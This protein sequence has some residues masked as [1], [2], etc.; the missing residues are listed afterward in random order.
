[1]KKRIIS[2]IMIACL[3]ISFAGCGEKGSDSKSTKTVKVKSLEPSEKVEKIESVKNEEDFNTVYANFAFEAMKASKEA[4]EN[5]MISPLSIIT[6]LSMTASGADNDTLK[7]MEKVLYGGESIDKIIP[8]LMYYIDSI[9]GFGTDEESLK[10][11]NSIWIKDDAGLHVS[12]DFLKRNAET[13]GNEVFKVAFDDNTLAALNNWVKNNTDGMIE[14]I[15]DKMDEDAVMYLINAI[16]FEARWRETYM[17]YQVHDNVTFHDENGTNES[18]TMLCS[19]ESGYMED[20]TCTGV[21]KAYENG[22]SFVALLPN[23]GM[24]V[25]DLVKSMDGGKWNNLMSNIDYNPD[26][27][28]KIPQFKF[29][30]ATEMSSVLEDLGMP[31]AFDRENADFTKMATHDQ[32]NLFINRVIHKTFIDLDKNGTKAAASTVVE[33]SL[34]TAMVQE[35]EPV[36]KEV[37]LDRPFIFAIVDDISM[38]PVFVG[39]VN[40]IY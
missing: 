16:A 34:E 12:D 17:D 31:S 7:E 20:E 30:Y 22:Y 3:A 37:I 40:H 10:Q 26:V 27:I 1:M 5:I 15:L 35:E 29:E 14:E 25:E 38:L 32:G 8:E 4:G 28:T 11:A 36:I 24:S 33:V 21:K 39:T 9:T 2:I 13:F 19:T 18:V 23:E 6:A